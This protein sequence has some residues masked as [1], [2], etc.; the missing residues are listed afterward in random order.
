VCIAKAGIPP[1]HPND[2]QESEIE[3]LLSPQHMNDDIV[4]IEGQETTL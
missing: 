3:R 4:E 2:K 1:L